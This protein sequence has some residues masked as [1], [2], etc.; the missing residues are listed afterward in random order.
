MISVFQDAQLRLQ[1]LGEISGIS[2]QVI[3]NLSHPKSTLCVSLA[4]LMDDG[5]TEYFDAYRCQYS[6]LLGT[7]KAWLYG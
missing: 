7:C 5:S 1:T 4:V 6:S 2:S 3:E